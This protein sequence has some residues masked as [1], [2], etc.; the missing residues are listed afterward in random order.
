MKEQYITEIVQYVTA[1][2]EKH[3]KCLAELTHLV[4]NK[5]LTYILTFVSKLFGSH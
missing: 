1:Q 5:R 4:D 3:I 2:D